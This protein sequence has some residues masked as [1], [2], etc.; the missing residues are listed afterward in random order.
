MIINDKAT[1][2]TNRK[3][4]Y[5]WGMNA[6]V[7]W[8]HRL[9]L[10]TFWALCRGIGMMPRCVRYYILK[11]FIWVV[12]V[13]SGYRRKTI[14]KNLMCSFPDK[15]KGE[16]G[17]LM[18]RY[19]LFMAEL[20]VDVLSLAGAGEKTKDRA[21]D[22]VNA[23]E[24]HRALDGRD[25]IAMGA[26]YG[27]WEYLPLWAR[28]QADSVFMSVYH[29]LKSVVF[30]MF[31]Q[32]LRSFSPGVVQVPMKQTI[33]YYLKN[34]RPGR[35]MVLGLLSD[36]SPKMRAD[37][38][39][40]R[41][42]NQYTIFNDGAEALALKFHLPVYFAYTQRLA[43]GRYAVRCDEIY[44]G[45]EEV[46]PNEITER[47]VRRLESMILECPELW[48]WSHNRWRHS[49]ESQARRFGQNTLVDQN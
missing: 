29:P 42:L 45:V 25:W 3:K 7:K 39:W 14:R 23:G 24:M 12:L 11:P 1:R 34:R 2:F 32:R 5:L 35:S 43:P 22:W 31:Y 8:Y 13:L 9:G 37:S 16:I 4:V 28:Q 27:C 38:H 47:Y 49:P 40:F 18:R 46:Q 6:E 36:Q 48:V 44:D 10:E 21:V 19:Y 26:H 41:F 30:E 17:G 15:S 33:R 20:V